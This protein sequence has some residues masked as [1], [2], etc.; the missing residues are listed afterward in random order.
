MQDEAND[1]TGALATA[2][3][4]AGGAPPVGR[5]RPLLDRPR[6]TN[7]STVLGIVHGDG[8]TSRSELT[9]LTG[10]NRS[11][12]AA[13]VGELV[14]RGLVVEPEPVAAN[15]VGRPS[16]VSAPRPTSSPSR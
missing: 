11:T 4:D 16:P 8:P 9:R 13:L 1:T 6:G 3:P 7:L 14:E 2:L 5:T 10:L 15:R 12:I